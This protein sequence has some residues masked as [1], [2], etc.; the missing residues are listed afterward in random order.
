M[1]WSTI[2]ASHAPEGCEDRQYAIIV[3]LFLRKSLGDRAFSFLWRI[4][5]I[6]FKIYVSVMRQ[7]TVESYYTPRTHDIIDLNNK[8]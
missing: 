2:P 4:L 3:S 8:Y 7:G 5:Q 1:T 6:Y